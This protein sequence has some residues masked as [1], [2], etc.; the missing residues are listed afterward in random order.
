MVPERTM[1]SQAT[2]QQ[3]WQQQQQQQQQQI[4]LHGSEARDT[5]NPVVI[6]MQICF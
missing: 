6:I 4:S 3:S 2:Q 1:N 5:T